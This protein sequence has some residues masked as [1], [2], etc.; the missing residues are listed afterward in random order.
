MSE[1]VTAVL[2]DVDG[3]LVDSNYLHAVTWWEAFSQ[4]GYD[5]A[6][7]DIHRAIGMGSDQMLDKLLPSDRDTGQDDSLRTAHSAL[8]SAY[9]ARLRPLRR[10]ADLLRACKKH[11]LT[12]V[13]A[14]SADEP[15]FNAL[16]AALDAEDAID[17]AT[18]SGEVERS[19]PAPDLVQ[20]ALDKAGVSADEAVFVG[21]TVWDVHAARKAGVRCVCLLSGGISRGEL[22]DAG[23][24]DVYDDPADLLSHFPGALIGPPELHDRPAVGG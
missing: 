2:F 23:A 22:A 14:S 8:Y 21:D 9:W 20:V 3:T 11:G 13:L 15:E 1:S 19:K 5:V 16:R 18:F 12:V 7:A 6:M 4:A 10:A 17:A 24:N